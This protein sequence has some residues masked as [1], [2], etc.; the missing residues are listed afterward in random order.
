MKTFNIS[1]PRLA[2]A[3]IA[4]AAVMFNGCSEDSPVDPPNDVEHPEPTRMVLILVNS[5]DGADSAQATW[6]DADG[7]GGN[8]PSR[9]DTLRLKQGA[10]YNGVLRLYNDQQSVE[11]T[12][13]I[14]E[15]GDQ[16]QF[17]Y[18][19]SAPIAGR[20]NVTITDKDA[21]NLPLG[22]SYT[23]AVGAGDPAAGALNVVLG[24][25]DDAPKDGTT[26]SPESDID[27]DIPV[28][29]R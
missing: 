28:L 18:T 26:R 20:V 3:A 21:K 25:Y 24:H 8:A 22:L 16:H 13:F 29:I 10:T 11:V 4:I 1:R 23:V 17:F 5:T 2:L 27:V 14:K 6:Q 7:I 9:I 15:E 19:P 12:P